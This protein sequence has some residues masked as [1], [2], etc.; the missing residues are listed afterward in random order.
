MIHEFLE[1]QDF[2]YSRYNIAAIV[3]ATVFILL[4]W[5]VTI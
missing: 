4:M 3:G 5:V 2:P 1:P